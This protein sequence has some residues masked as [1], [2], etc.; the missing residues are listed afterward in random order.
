MQAQP[1][2]IVAKTPHDGDQ[3]IKQLHKLSPSLTRLYR[4][5]G[6]GRTVAQ[7]VVEFSM[8]GE[9]EQMLD[10]LEGL[11]FIEYL[12]AERTPASAVTSAMAPEPKPQSTPQAAPEPEPEPAATETVD[13]APDRLALWLASKASPV[14]RELPQVAFSDLSRSLSRRGPSVVM[15]KHERL[16]EPTS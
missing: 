5:V 6:N 15:P 9:V 14:A 12:P 8:L 7:T 13:P 16:D 2:F 3:A 4:M 10:R 11:G 1:H